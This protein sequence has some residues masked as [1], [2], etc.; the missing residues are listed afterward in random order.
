MIYPVPF[1]AA[2]A[3]Q[4]VLQPAQA[5]LNE[6]WTPD[7]LEGLECLWAHTLMLDGAPV[8]CGGVLAFDLARGTLWA[9][10][11]AGLR[12]V[13][14]LAVHRI[15]ARFLDGLPFAALDMYVDCEFTNGHRWATQLGFTCKR[16]RM[17]G[18][19]V[20]GGDCAYYVRERH[21]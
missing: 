21:G 11:G 14:F 9:F 3:G 2:H 19:Q 20:N 16:E 1:R 7:L 13:E 8:F 15:V 12:P 6:Y 4:L 18:F 10:V 5:W 17:Q